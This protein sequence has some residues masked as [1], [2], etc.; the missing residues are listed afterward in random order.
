MRQYATTWQSRS[1][2]VGWP[3][4]QSMLA[5]VPI[6][7]WAL[8]GIA[9]A[10]AIAGVFSGWP[11]ASNPEALELRDMLALKTAEVS[12]LRS[13][14]ELRT[15]EVERLRAVHE[16]SSEFGI[17]ADQATQ[18]YD[19]ALAED[20][21][22]DLA[23]NLVRV[24]SGFHRTAVSSAGAIGYTQI[25]PSTAR[26]LDPA[27]ET[28]DLFDSATNLHLGFRYFRYLLDEY[29]GDTRLALLAYNRGPGRV[30]DL[31]ISGIDPANGYAKAVLGE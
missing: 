12:D 17:S 5:E 21:N 3:R 18:I 14:M 20:V 16:Y 30:G 28:T 19:I 2:S 13:E 29:N 1:V 25:R 24:E 11:A 31:L 7:A 22:P 10:L 6:P 9:G 8:C 4:I 26:W 27:V 23:F 15:L